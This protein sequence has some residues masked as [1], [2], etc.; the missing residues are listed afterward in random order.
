LLFATA[1]LR[2]ALLGGGHAYRFE[3]D[4]FRDGLEL[5]RN[6]A[7]LLD[8]VGEARL[9]FGHRVGKLGACK[10]DQ[11]TYRSGVGQRTADDPPEAAELAASRER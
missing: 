3:G 11:P 6:V 1:A 2:K 10:L 5:F 7:H 4:Y 8:A 9:L